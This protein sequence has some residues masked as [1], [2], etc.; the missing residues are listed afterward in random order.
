MNTDNM[1]LRSGTQIVKLKNFHKVTWISIMPCPIKNKNKNPHNF[2][3]TLYF[4]EHFYVHCFKH[5]EFD[6]KNYIC[7]FAVRNTESLIDWLYVVQ[8]AKLNLGSGLGWFCS[9]RTLGSELPVPAADDLFLPSACH[10]GEYDK[11][12]SPSLPWVLC[13]TQALDAAL[14]F[15]FTC[16]PERLVFVCRS[17]SK[18]TSNLSSSGFADSMEHRWQRGQWY[19][20]RIWL[21]WAGWPLDRQ[22][23]EKLWKEWRSLQVGWHA[24]LIIA[25]FPHAAAEWASLWNLKRTYFNFSKPAS[26]A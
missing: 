17:N 22:H 25:C 21:G 26:C 1:F 19:L 6:Y 4:L 15:H 23:A 10:L 3:G 7:M 18:P 16:C 14:G 24:Y 5:Y 11:D 8:L 13:W 2:H 9:L 12:S 20:S